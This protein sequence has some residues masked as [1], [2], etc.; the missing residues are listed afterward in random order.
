MAATDTKRAPTGMKHLQKLVDFVKYRAI[1][2]IRPIDRRIGV[3]VLGETGLASQRIKA[4]YAR[5]K[6][7]SSEPTSLPPLSEENHE[8][9][10]AIRE[11]GFCRLQHSYDD[12]L[13]ESI[14]ESFEELIADQDFNYTKRGS[15]GEIYMDGFMNDERK[16]EVDL[17]EHFPEMKDILT[18]DIKRHLAA[19]YQ[20]WFKPTS[21]Q[22]YRTHHIPD[23][24][25]SEI[26]SN[27]WHID[28]GIG[29]HKLKLF[30]LLSDVDEEGGPLRTVSTDETRR[31]QKEVDYLSGNRRYSP[32]GVIE[33]KADDVVT[34]T[35]RQGSSLFCRTNVNLHRAGVPAE[36][37]HRDILQIVFA[38]AENPLPDNWLAALE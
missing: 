29:T 21:V 23:H 26:Y 6:I 27:H 31:I 11:N 7:A 38:P 2:N 16:K 8:T 28:E 1:N 22:M 20:S 9:A 17:R 3:Q 4:E 24:V 34:F 14:Q 37:Q 25:G 33:E 13:I 15:D 36:G 5:K 19:Y 18:E 12:S 32:D 10:T 30:V 35:G